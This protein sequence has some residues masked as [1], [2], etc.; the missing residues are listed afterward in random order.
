[1]ATVG[2]D[3]NDKRR[4]YS[5]LLQAREERSQLG[6]CDRSIGEIS[7]EVIIIIF[8]DRTRDLEKKIG[9]I[10]G[11]TIYTKQKRN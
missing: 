7:A 1:L 5:L 3:S 6:V 8:N 2:I 10:E 11:A 9:K 4:F